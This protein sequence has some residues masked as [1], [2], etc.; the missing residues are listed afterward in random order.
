LKVAHLADPDG[1]QFACP[2]SRIDPQGEQAQI[3]R[4]VTQTAFDDLD[5]FFGAD[6]FDLDARSAR[7]VVGILSFLQAHRVLSKTVNHYSYNDIT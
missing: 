5:G 7:R 3:T 2:E 4:V 1:E 6:R